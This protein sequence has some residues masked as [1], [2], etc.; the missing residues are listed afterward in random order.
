MKAFGISEKGKYRQENQD[1]ILIEH[2]NDS[3]LMIVADGVGGAQAGAEVSRY[4]TERYHGWWASQMRILREKG[5]PEL[6]EEIKLL[7]EE[8]NES[9]CNTY[10]TGK[11]AS[12]L[13][14]LFIHRS[15]YGCLSV[16]DSRVY[17]CSF[18]KAECITR[19]DIW[20]NLPG[21]RPYGNHKGKL[22]SAV[23][24]YRQLEYS[25]MTDKCKKG[26]VFLLCSDGIYRFAEPGILS[27]A[28]RRACFSP[29]YGKKYLDEIVG[30]ALL[31]DTK[32]NYSAIMVKT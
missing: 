30:N 15:I 16:G 20:E 12:T 1:S 14:L 2:C 10:G 23:G 13:A 3:G 31:H 22:V 11:S 29:A 21:K 25:C 4:I 8:I 7:A 5:F 28:M 17:K 19:D 32:D 26:M 24:G 27:A 18:L 9:I 6:F